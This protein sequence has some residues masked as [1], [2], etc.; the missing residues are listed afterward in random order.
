[1]N[2][3]KRVFLMTLVLVHCL[4]LTAQGFSLKMRN[5]PVGKAITELKQKTG[6]S[7]IYASQDIDSKRVVSIDASS[8]NEAVAQILEGQNVSFNVQGKNVI[9]KKEEPKPDEDEKKPGVKTLS[10]RV[11][12]ENNSGVAGASV[13]V[14]GET[15]GVIAD[16]DG[17]FSVDVKKGDVLIFSFLGYSDQEIQITDQ[18][19]LSVKLIPKTSE[20]EEVTVVAYGTQRKASVIGAISTVNTVQL[21][22]PVGMLSSGLA[23]KLAGIVVMQRTGEPGAGADFWIRGV[24]T[25]GA[26]SRPLVLVDGIQRDMDLVDLDDIA[27]FSILKDATATALYGVKGANGIVVITTKRGAESAPK[28]DFK[29]EYGFTQPVKLPRLANTS[30]WID[31]F[32]QIYLDEGGAAPI[33]QA[34][35]EKHL[36]GADPD[37]Y[38]SVDWIK[39]IYKDMA[40]TNKIN[41]SVT[42][43]TRS[44]RYYVGGSYY[45]EGGIFNVARN[46]RYDA[47]MNF[48]RF[49]FRSNVDIDITKTTA[50]GLSLSTQ[51][52]SKNMPS[53]NLGNLYAYTLYHTPVATPTVYSDG[54][55][56]NPENGNNPYNLLNEVGYTRL[57]TITAQSMLSLTQDLS[58]YVTEGLKLNAK[59]SWDGNNGNHL[60]RFNSPSYYYAL[61]RDSDG[62]LI[63]KEQTIGSNYMSLWRSNSSWTTINFEAS[64]LWERVFGGAHR[65]SAMFLYNLRKSTN[66][67]PDSYI[68]AFAY[69][70]MGIA[71]RA[72]YSFKDRYFA[73]FNFGYNGSENFAPGHRFGFFPS[74]AVGYMISNENFWSGI[75][76]VVDE[77]KFR[78]SYGKIGNDQ[79]GGGRRFAYNTTMNTSAAGFTFGTNGG[80]YVSGITTGDF[81]NP[82]VEWEEAK[83]ANIGVEMSFFESLKIQVD[84]F[85]DIR[86]G[87]FIK[88]ESMPSVVGNNIQQYVNLGRM[89]N[90]GFDIGMQYEHVF[91]NKLYLSARANYAFNRNKKLYDDKPDQIWKYQNLAGFAYGQQFGLIAEGLFEDQKDI[92]SWPEQK[93]GKAQPGDIKYRDINGDGIVDTYDKVAIGYTTIPEINYGFGISAS[94]HGID[95]S[96]FFTG[97]GNVTR[98][99]HGQLLFGSSYNVMR[100][101]QVYED[102]ALYHWTKIRPNPDAEYPRISLN[103]ID[104]NEQP[105]TYWQRDMSFMRLKNAEIGYTFPKRLSKPIGLSVI[106]FYVQGSN[107]LTFTKFKL[108]DPELDASYGNVYPTMRCVTLGLNLNF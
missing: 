107:L 8:L 21:A 27:S 20:L 73:E 88:R 10:G 18:K 2:Y 38:P 16:M 94:W 55:L 99:I 90:E 35:K 3:T 105:S 81:G 83:K 72:T 49:S 13:V 77:L 41:V 30:Q 102:V 66:N 89:K 46:D 48:N 63:F 84:Y 39:T 61:G 95:A 28:V 97:V 74:I 45:H 44:V 57:N 68:Y 24:N 92:D 6:Y 23:G 104:N 70:N 79:I 101:G 40:A 91:P 31:F 58:P 32:N 82:N 4:S 50:L 59:F 108:W 37:L 75:K 98:I 96:V 34:D 11:I 54:T 69:K 29:A 106:R 78:A 42:G 36:S 80:K 51:Y 93:F 67:V 12:D 33:S 17:K 85:K 5:V 87:I 65:A 76:D 14:K 15:R 64:A 103:K 52:T 47:Q 53:G 43:G 1:M 62:K 7:F 86:T 26:N 100:Q 60:N 9:V 19:E 22:A 56:A 25:F 71:G